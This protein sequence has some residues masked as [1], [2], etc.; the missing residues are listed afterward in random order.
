MN[1]LSM[2]HFR[3]PS[4]SRP[5]DTGNIVRQGTRGFTL[6][7]LLAVMAIMAIMTEALFLSVAGM[8]TS[9]GMTSAAYDIQG[10][11]NRARTMAISHDTYVWV[12]FYEENPSAAGNPGTGQLVIS[13]VSSA[14]GTQLYSTSSSSSSATP[15][16]LDSTRLVQSFKLE[17]IA[18][19]H[20]D[21]I[22]TASVPRTTV[23]SDPYQ[24]GDSSFANNITFPFPLT[25][26]STYTFKNVIQFDPQGDATRIGDMP[27]TLMEIGLQPT[28]GSTINTTSKNLIA[29]QVS[30]IGGGVTVYRPQ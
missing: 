7:E 5:C 25:G 6:V 18:N 1:N 21:V 27:A 24:M 26:N 19:V 23:P 17:K 20:L 22:G 14:D 2:V 3:S 28:H 10:I 9:Q 29:L 11:L 13:T 8:Q 4:S 16:A 30:G 15:V 12:G